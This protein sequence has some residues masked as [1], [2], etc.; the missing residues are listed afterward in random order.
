ML[1][2]ANTRPA[3]WRDALLRVRLRQFA[4]MTEHGPPLARSGGRGPREGRAPW[5]VASEFAELLHLVERGTRARGSRKPSQMQAWEAVR[6]PSDAFVEPDPE[7]AVAFVVPIAQFGKQADHL[8]VRRI[9][10][11]PGTVRAARL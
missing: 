2:K 11:H 7:D 3:A 10:D 5:S 6:V 8:L 1:P 4:A 9:H